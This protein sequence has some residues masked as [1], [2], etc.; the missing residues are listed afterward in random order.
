M[1]QAVRASSGALSAPRDLAL[2]FIQLSRTCAR[3]YSQLPRTTWTTSHAATT[4]SKTAPSPLTTRPLLRCKRPDFCGQT[5]LSRY[6]LCQVARLSVSTDAVRVPTGLRGGCTQVF[7]SM[8]S[9]STPVIRRDKAMSS[10]ME[11]GSILI[12]SATSVQ[13]T[14]E[15]MA[16]LLP[17]IPSLQY[18]R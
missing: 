15:T 12:E 17:L 7:V 13:R 5:G 1:W 2:H 3:A 11:T 4:S 16:T 14:T 6:Y 18:F 9:G 10:F 8:G